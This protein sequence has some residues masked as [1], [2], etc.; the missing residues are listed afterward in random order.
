[1]MSSDGAMCATVDVQCQ[2]RFPICVR[3]Q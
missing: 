3:C 2:Q 1:V